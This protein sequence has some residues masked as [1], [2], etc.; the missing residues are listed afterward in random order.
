MY[1]Y[2][3]IYV[4]AHTYILNALKRIRGMAYAHIERACV[5]VN[6]KIDSSTMNMQTMRN[7]HDDFDVICHAHLA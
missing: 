6:V 1:K 5:R 7:N 2:V 3:F 4:C